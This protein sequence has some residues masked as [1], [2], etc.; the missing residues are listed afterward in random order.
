MSNLNAL[1]DGAR[2][3]G[4]PLCNV[5]LACD[6][7]TRNAIIDVLRSNATAAS[8]V[9]DAIAWLEAAFPE[10]RN[11]HAQPE[12][13]VGSVE[14]RLGRWTVAIAGGING[15]YP[16]FSEYFRA[17]VDTIFAM[18]IE[19]GDLQRLRGVADEDDT[20]VITGH[21]TSDSIGINVVIRELEQ[22]G[23]EVVRTSGVVA[24]A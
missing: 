19:E 22:R 2:L 12:V 16:V 9:S 17:G 21:V 3:V 5:H 1:V 6:I 24:P 14:T 4:M 23:V 11:G 7:I 10:Y 18:H 8:T 15:G 13:W 20:L